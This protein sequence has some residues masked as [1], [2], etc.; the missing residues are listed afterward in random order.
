MVSHEV[1][2]IVNSYIGRLLYTPLA[3]LGYD[4]PGFNPSEIDHATLGVGSDTSYK[5]AIGRVE[6]G[7]HQ[8]HLS[9]QSLVDQDPVGITKQGS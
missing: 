6:T 2:R 3:P 7:Y 1:E 5:Q 4:A 8:V 9:V